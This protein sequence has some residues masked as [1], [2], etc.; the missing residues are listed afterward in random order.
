VPGQVAGPTFTVAASVRV[1]QPRLDRLDLSLLIRRHLV[2]RPLRLSF[3][4][5]LTGVHFPGG[6]GLRWLRLL[7]TLLPGYMSILDEVEKG[8]VL[9]PFCFH[10]AVSRVRLKVSGIDI[11]AQICARVRSQPLAR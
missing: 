6:F 5:C 11:N 2:E 1:F 4:G 7:N 3:L 9:V 10:D 8:H